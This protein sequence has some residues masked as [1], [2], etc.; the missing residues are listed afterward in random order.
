[1]PSSRIFLPKANNGFHS[2]FFPPN[3][4]E[5]ARLHISKNHSFLPLQKIESA[6]LEK[7]W[8]PQCGALFLPLQ[9]HHVPKAFLLWVLHYRQSACSTNQCNRSAIAVSS[10]QLISGY[11][12]C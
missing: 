2:S 12:F 8:M 11:V 3:Y 5:V 6:F 10:L 9:V 4:N 7:D 1:K